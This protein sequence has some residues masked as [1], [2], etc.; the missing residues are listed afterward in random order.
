MAQ[1]NYVNR[2]PD[3]RDLDLDFFANPSTGDVYKKEGEEAIKRS[4]R[5]ILFTNFYE[6]L[7]QPSVGSNVRKLLFEPV[8]PFTLNLLQNAI[9]ETIN[10]F[11]PRVTL[12]DVVVSSDIDN[13]GFNVRLQYVIKNRNMPVDTTLFLERIR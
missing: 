6:R 13:N 9:K 8:N 11:E 5:N 4:V 12:V 1:I 2:N 10:N 3:Y 7:F